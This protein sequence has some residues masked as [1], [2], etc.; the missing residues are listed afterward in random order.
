MINELLDQFLAIRKGKT[1][2][3]QS[4][5]SIYQLV[6]RLRDMKDVDEPSS[7]FVQ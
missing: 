5:Y 4:S 7:R 2:D 1:T 3:F 6:E